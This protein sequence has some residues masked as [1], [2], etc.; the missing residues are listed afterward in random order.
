MESGTCGLWCGEDIPSGRRWNRRERRGRRGG[1]T[2]KGRFERANEA[3][4]L[5]RGEALIQLRK[6]ALSFGGRRQ[7]LAVSLLHG[8][9]AVTRTFLVLRGA[10]RRGDDG[11][12][13]FIVAGHV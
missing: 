6:I 2:L 9:A 4:A 8:K 10:T 5:R 11:R 12:R 7:S 13:P 1:R 3:I